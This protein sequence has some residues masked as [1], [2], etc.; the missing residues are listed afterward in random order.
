MYWYD[1]LQFDMSARFEKANY[2]AVGPGDSIEID[3]GDLPSIYIRADNSGANDVLS[4]GTPGKTEAAN[5]VL[6]AGNVYHNGGDGNPAYL[7]R[8]KTAIIVVEIKTTLVGIPDGFARQKL[9]V[10]TIYG[11]GLNITDHLEIAGVLVR[12]QK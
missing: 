12:A 10:E 5:K 4:V 6:H 3:R 1:M 11:T 7:E 9:G 8:G 2:V